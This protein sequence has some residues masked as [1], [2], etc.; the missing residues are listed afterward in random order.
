MEQ[1]ERTAIVRALTDAG[2]NR[3]RA[4][5]LAGIGRATLYRKIRAY[6]LDAEST[7]I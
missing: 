6:G 5:E 4:A 3:T 7:L 2:G 1:V